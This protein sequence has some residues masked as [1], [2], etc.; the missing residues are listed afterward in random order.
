MSEQLKSIADL[1]IHTL[2]KGE[3]KFKDSVSSIA[4]S[5][6]YITTEHFKATIGAQGSLEWGYCIVR[7]VEG[8]VEG[9]L[10]KDGSFDV[11][12]GANL[13]RYFDLREADLENFKQCLTELVQNGES[14]I[15]ELHEVYAT[16]RQAR[17]SQLP[18]GSIPAG[19]NPSGLA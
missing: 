11:S 12:H 5:F 13:E 16:H 17:M 3:V 14:K 6:V 9:Y 7:D 10:Q 2:E 15:Q 1:L 18:Q 8:T 4:H 19:L